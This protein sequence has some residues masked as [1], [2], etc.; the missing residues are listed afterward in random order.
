MHGIRHIKQDRRVSE[1]RTPIGTTVVKAC[2]NQR[3][4]AVALSSSEVVYFELDNAGNLNEYQEHQEMSSKVCSIALSPVP[5]G[6]QRSLF[7]VFLLI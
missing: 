4:V 7:L 6:R 2:C 1:W 3:Q 5:R